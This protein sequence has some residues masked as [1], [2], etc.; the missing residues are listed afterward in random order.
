MSEMIP[1]KS[2]IRTRS[3]V[4]KASFRNIAAAA[5]ALAATAPA[6]WADSS[7]SPAAVPGPGN[8]QGPGWA[9]YGSGPWMMGGWGGGPMM[10]YGGYGGGGWIMMIFG[11]VIVVALLVFIFRASVWTAYP[12]YQ[13]MPHNRAN[14]VGLHALD[15]RYARSEI[16][17]EEYLQKK[18]DILEG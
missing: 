6:A 9:G 18:R 11:A 3:N 17:R 7:A 12:P 2:S 5:L 14:S 16:N 1:A 13:P 10:G 8:F 15:E 4:M